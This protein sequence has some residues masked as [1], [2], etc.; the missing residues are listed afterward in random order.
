MHIS[1]FLAFEYKGEEDGDY[2]Y[3]NE[4]Y[5]IQR[6]SGFMDLY[7]DLGVLLGMDLDTE[8]VTFKANGKEY[9]LQFWKG[10]YAFGG[11]YGGEIGLYSR[12]EILADLFP[13]NE[14]SVGSKLINYQ[15]ASG[16][17]EI[18]STQTIYNVD[19]NKLLEHSTKK[20][21]DNDDHFW[22]LAIKT[23]PGYSAEDLSIREVIEVKNDEVYEAMKDAIRSNPDLELNEERST[24]NK[25][26]LKY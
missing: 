9:R 1:D 24:E 12:S 20:N 19:G 15:C 22:N 7:D 25:I 2:Y 3:T 11:A 10:S 23:D 18:I 16:E 4:T 26:V 6:C 21:A 8:I 5:G 14:G 17:D 13:Y